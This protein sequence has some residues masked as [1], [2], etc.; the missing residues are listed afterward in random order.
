PKVEILENGIYANA[1][2]WMGNS[3]Y[4]EMNDGEIKL[5][6]YSKKLKENQR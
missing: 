6:E 5:C 2:D 4:L 3:T 1:G